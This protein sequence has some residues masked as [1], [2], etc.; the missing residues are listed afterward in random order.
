MI[1]KSLNSG[2]ILEHAPGQEI[3]FTLDNPM[4]ED[5]RIPVPVSTAI[6][7]PPTPNNKAVFGFVEAMMLAPRVQT[8]P[9]VIIVGG[10]EIFT[11]EMQFDEYSDGMLKYTF[12]GV[13][14]DKILAGKIYEVQTEVYDDIRLSDFVQN[15]RKGSYSDF[16]LP[17][18]IRQPNSA[19]VEYQ[20]DVEAECSIIDKYVNYLYE[21]IPYIVPVINCWR[22]LREIIPMAYFPTDAE[23]V[24]L[25]MGIVAPYKPEGWRS[26]YI[27]APVEWVDDRLSG[28]GERS[29]YYKI[30]NFRPT[31]GLPDMSNRDFLSNL[32]KMFCSTLF[33]N[34]DQYS[35]ECNKDILTS[36]NFV[37]WTEKVSEV[38]SI[39]TGEESGY[40]LEYANENSNYTPPKVDDLGQAEI[41]P[42]ITTCATYYDMLQKFSTAEDYINIQIK[43]TKNIYSGKHIDAHLYYEYGHR[44]KINWHSMTTPVVTLD[45]VYQAG[46]EPR[47][48]NR[49]ND[50]TKLFENT[51]GFNC[52]KS[53]PACVATPIL[54]SSTDSQ[55]TLACLSPIIDFPTVGGERPTTAYIG[56]VYRENMFDQGN[57]FLDIIPYIVEGSEEEQPYSLALAGEGGLYEKFHRVFA[58][59]LTKKKDAIK[60]DI[61]LTPDDV[62]NLRLFKKVM[63]YNRLFLIKSIEITISDHHDIAFANAELVEV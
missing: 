29:G 5:D 26:E 31:E 7:F 32:L 44:G 15:A 63:I 57:Y 56:L 30:S 23:N 59:W 11:G 13:G 45:I 61:F 39:V 20:T 34:G 53:V 35:I 12:V 51:I 36:T 52:A 41:D 8:L 28:S 24:I 17:Q 22:L 50:D 21:P 38:Y 54:L 25:K 42:S 55:V 62:V 1:I 18:I 49:R 2:Q 6:E 9:V 58:E 43:N 40:S 60:A 19:K 27:G 33:I 48:V 46:L 4:F 10:I 3:C 37:D 47:I 16:S 14:A